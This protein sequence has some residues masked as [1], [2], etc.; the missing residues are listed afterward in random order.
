MGL[1]PWHSHNASHQVYVN[2]SGNVENENN[3]C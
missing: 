3:S 2:T 1:G